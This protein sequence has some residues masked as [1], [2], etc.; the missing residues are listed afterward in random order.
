MTTA[1]DRITIQSLTQRKKDYRLVN[2]LVGLCKIV[3]AGT[4]L[5]NIIY[6]MLQI[7]FYCFVLALVGFCRQL[8]RAETGL[9]SE[10]SKY[11]LFLNNYLQMPEK[12][13]ITWRHIFQKIFSYPFTMVMNCPQATQLTIIFYNNIIHDL[14][15]LFPVNNWTMF[16][17]VRILMLK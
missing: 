14:V 7:H 6:A 12:Y 9:L 5:T 11:Q 8:I 13:S 10:L 3:A 2:N 16:G 4:K 17:W 15:K 1:V